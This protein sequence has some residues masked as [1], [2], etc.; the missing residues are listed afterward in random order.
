MLN[1][2]FWKLINTFKIGFLNEVNVTNPKRILVMRYGFLGDVLQTTPILN[3]LHKKWPKAKIDYWVS[4]TAAPALANNTYVSDILDADLFGQLNIK[5]PLPILRYALFLRKKHY[6]LAVCLGSDPFYGLLAWLSGVRYRIGLIVNK[7]K[8]VFLHKWIKTPLGDRVSRQRRYLELIKQLDIEVPV[9]EEH[10]QIFW[11]KDDTAKVEEL[12]GKEKG[13]LVAIFCGSGPMRFRPWANRRWDIRNWI[14]LTQKIIKNYSDIK[15][16]LLGT[17]QEL[18]STQNIKSNLP[19]NKVINLVG[20]TNFAQMGPILK[21]CRMLVSNDSSPIFVAA[22]VGCP[23]VAIYGPEW[24]ERA[25]PIGAQ[26]W[27][28]IF[29]DIDCRDYCASFPDQAPNCKTECM[30][31]ITVEM[32]LEKIDHVL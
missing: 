6:D 4:R 16:V 28:P 25:R 14:E 8:A 11:I 27:V 22:A 29:V 21:R 26:N 3:A 9:G 13:N 15:I 18:E 31:S 2:I 7:D 10:I 23:V 24:P 1:R 5:K 19:Q 12:L 30:S 20:K 32:V 17:A